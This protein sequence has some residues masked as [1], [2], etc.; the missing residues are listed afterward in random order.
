MGIL[1]KDKKSAGILGVDIGGSSIKIVELES[2]KGRSQLITYGYLERSLKTAQDSLLENPEEMAKSLKKVASAAKVKTKNAVT[3]LPASAVF[4]TILNLPDMKRKDLNSTKIVTK[5]VE[6]EAK[7]VLPMKLEEMIL[8]WKILGDNNLDESEEQV[9]GIQILLTAAA[10][11]LVQK[12]VGIF[13]KADMNLLSLETESFALS[14]ALVGKDASSVI[15]VDI[16]SSNTDIV[17]VD[18]TVPY[19][20]RSV[21]TGGYDITS[22][23]SKNMKISLEQ[24]EQFKRDLANYNQALPQGKLL[25]EVIEKAITPIVNEVKYLFDFYSKQSGKKDKRIDRIILSGGTAKIFN[26]PQY[27][28]EKFNVRTFLGDPWA[29]VIFP[30]E[31]KPVLN[32]IGSRLAVSIGLAMREIEK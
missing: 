28:T 26:M 10:K 17:V 25:P 16:G 3:A 32:A 23:L 5:A 24:A 31:L 6:E 27:F 9:S 22:V 21:S 18:N 1:S 11:N 13:K 12:F 14:R 19:I 2:N 7:K 15:I 8:D 20:E 29:R 30:E 4:T